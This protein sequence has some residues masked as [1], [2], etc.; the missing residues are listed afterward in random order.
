MKKEIKKRNHYKALYLKEKWINELYGKLSPETKS[1]VERILL[2]GERLR[3]DIE[4][5]WY[6]QVEKR[7]KLS[8]V[9]EWL[10]TNQKKMGR[11]INIKNG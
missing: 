1:K 2:D 5:S 11:L 8:G 9:K 6:R 10:T 3:E 7:R 4:S